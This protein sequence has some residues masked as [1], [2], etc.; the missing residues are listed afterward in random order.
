[1]GKGTIT[2]NPYHADRFLL[3]PAAMAGLLATIHTC[4]DFK[5][6]ILGQAHYMLYNLVLAMHPRMLMTF[7]EEMNA[8]P[9]SPSPS[10]FSTLLSS[11][12]DG[13]YSGHF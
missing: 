3:R 6:L 4:F 1:M 11:V 13:S 2:L 5:N 10:S 12:P 9:V 8:L 7:D